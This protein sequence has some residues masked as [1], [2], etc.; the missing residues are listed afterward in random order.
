MTRQFCGWNLSLLGSS[1]SNLIYFLVRP[2]KGIESFFFHFFLPSNFH[3]YRSPFEACIS[4]RW[5]DREPGVLG[6]TVEPL[7]G[8]AVSWGHLAL[9]PWTFPNQ[10]G[11]W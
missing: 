3:V 7:L 5:G 8:R 10:A 9:V 6:K 4:E 1:L 11:T 2:G